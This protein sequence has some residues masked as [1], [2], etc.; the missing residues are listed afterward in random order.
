MADPD[1]PEQ[2]VPVLPSVDDLP[3]DE[4]GGSIARFGFEYQDEV[5]VQF[6]LEMLTDPTLRKVYCETHDDIVLSWAPTADELIAEYVQVKSG[7][8]GQQWSVA[9]ICTK[10][11]TAS[12]YEKSLQ[13][14]RCK[15]ASRFRFVT[16]RQV[17]GELEVLTRPRN[18]ATRDPMHAA[19]KELCA[20]LEKRAP[21]FVSAK[22]GTSTYWVQHCLWQDGVAMEALQSS[23]RISLT[24]LA[25]ASKELLVM[26][27]IDALL[28]DLRVRVR[29]AGVAKWANGK[30]RKVITR[31]Q[32]VQ[33]WQAKLA[34]IR[35]RAE[36]PA[37]EN[38]RRKMSALPETMIKNAIAQRIRYSAAARTPRYME[39]DR[40]ERL[41]DVLHAELTHLQS[42]Y[43]KGDGATNPVDF[44]DACL[45]E[46]KRVSAGRL[47]DGEDQR[48]LQGL[49]YDIA[50]RCLLDFNRPL[51]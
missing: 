5:A 16:Q 1:I 26:E 51:R 44:H 33:W 15:E 50:D 38:L 17:D 41:S 8:Q 9:K 39:D 13:K 14:D 24:K 18:A 11:G 42:K 29:A 21:K 6:V 22:G 49:M 43:V 46:V 31:G 34:Q 12:A 47:S 25:M 48:F 35:E 40:G 45:D 19:S 2:P 30:E 20:E 23:N 4:E 3:P 28:D 37:G 36:A 7:P 10:S 32:I 27:Q